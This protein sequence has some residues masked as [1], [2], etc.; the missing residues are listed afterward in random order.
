M[1]RII[2]YAVVLLCTLVSKMYSQETF[3]KRAKSIA[4]NIRMVTQEQKDSLKMEVENIEKKRENGSISPETAATQK[5]NAAEK[6]AEIIE[7]RVAEQDAKLQQLIKDE[8]D[9]KTATEEVFG[10]TII[11]IGSSGNDSIG[12]HKTEINIGSMKIFK[13]EDQK[14]QRMAKRTTSQFVFAFGLNNLITD[15]DSNSVENS[16]FETWGSRFVEWGYTFNTRILKDNNLLHFKYGLSLMYNNLRPTGNRYFVKE[17]DVTTLQTFDDDLRENKFKNSMLV[18]PLHL[19]FDFTPKTVGDDGVTRFRTHKSVR[20]GIGGFAGLNYQS[21]QKLRYEED[22]I[23]IKNKQKGDF[24]V[25]TL[26]YGLSSYIGYGGTS[27]YVKYNLN[28]VFKDN[29]V[30]QHNISMGLRF[31]F[32]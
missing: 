17:G 11:V 28:P 14:I 19:E 3:E 18:L 12:K 30:D 16:D 6:R 21:T 20:L 26:V 32:N 31:D 1:Q 5:L 27:L 2:L 24:N 13:G 25:S 29:P 8:V 10:G 9:G 23:R 7:K 22:D 15:G 4:E